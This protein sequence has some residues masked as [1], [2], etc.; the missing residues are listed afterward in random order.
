MFLQGLKINLSVHLVVLIALGMIMVDF[1]MTTSFQKIFI[2]REIA[3]SDLIISTIQSQ[4]ENTYAADESFNPD[5]FLLTV[6]DLLK[7]SGYACSALLDENY[8]QV[9]RNTSLK[10]IGLYFSPPIRQAMMT[11]EKK[12]VFFGETWG[13]FWKADEYLLVGFPL[14]YNDTVVAGVGLACNLSGFYLALRKMQHLLLLFMVV[15]V[16]VL[17]FI[18]FYQLSKIAVNPIYR[19]LRRVD[20]FEADDQFFFHPDDKSNEFKRL[21]F[22]LNQMLARITQDKQMLRSTIASLEKSNNELKRAQNEIIKS[23]KLASVGRLSAG[24]AHEIGNPIS[25]ILGYIGLLKNENIKNEDKAEFITRAEKEI[26]RVKNII[27]QLLDYSQ[28]ASEGIQTFSSHALVND[29]IKMMSPQPIMKNIDVSTDLKAESDTVAGNPDLLLQVFLNLFLNAADAIAA[30]PNKSKGKII[31]SSEN[32]HG[33]QAEKDGDVIK[34]KFFDNG[35]GISEKY[36]ES[37]FDPFFTTKQPGK[38]TGLGLYVS[39]MIIENMGGRIEAISES[40]ETTVIIVTL[41][42]VHSEITPDTVLN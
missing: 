1:A 14:A 34:I 6:Q 39:F 18:G 37:L 27:R 5:D 19:L 33:S 42:T 30:G 22:S 4:F 36:K 16:V 13:V 38:G 12:T 24:I 41:N 26:I 28:P 17:S 21:S 25:I 31:I 23:E 20:E 2:N 7:N 9:Y 29:L 10:S 32:D 11:G 15:S 8:Q 40:R 35:T 3:N